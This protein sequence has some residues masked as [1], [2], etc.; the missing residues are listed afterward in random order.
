MAAQNPTLEVQYRSLAGRIR[1]ARYR[2]NMTQARWDQAMREHEEILS[3]LES[4]DGEALSAV[5]NQHLV[6][7]QETVK[8]AIRDGVGE[9]H[10]IA[11]VYD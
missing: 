10:G 9:A 7:K 3:A 5:L 8:Q 4:R 11:S 2:A 1:L 6:N